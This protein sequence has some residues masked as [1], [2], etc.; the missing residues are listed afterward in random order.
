MLLQNCIPNCAKLNSRNSS[1]AFREKFSQFS[2]WIH[3]IERM[4]QRSKWEST[5]EKN[6][7]NHEVSTVFEECWNDYK[8]TT[9]FKWKKF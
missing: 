3:F 9:N 2:Y 6:I 7:A 8:V 1:D 4:N 5:L